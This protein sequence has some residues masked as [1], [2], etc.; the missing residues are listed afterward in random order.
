MSAGKYRD[1]LNVQCV[2]SEPN[3]SNEMID[4]WSTTCEPWGEVKALTGSEHSLTPAQQNLAEVVYQIEMRADPS[5]T[6]ISP[7]M[8]VVWIDPGGQTVYLY[9]AAVLKSPDRDVVKLLAQER[10]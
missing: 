10:K 8:R 2:V 1:K 6:L 3:A 4:S 5:T 9:V 7:K